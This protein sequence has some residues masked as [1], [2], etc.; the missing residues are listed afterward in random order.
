MD[1]TIWS[2][3]SPPSMISLPTIPVF[4]VLHGELLNWCNTDKSVFSQ[5]GS[6]PRGLSI[7][8]PHPCFWDGREKW[9]MLNS[10]VNALQDFYIV[11]KNE[12]CRIHS[13]WFDHPKNAGEFRRSDEY[14]RET[15]DKLL[16]PT[17]ETLMCFVSEYGIADPSDDRLPMSVVAWTPAAIGAMMRMR[18]EQPDRPMTAWIRGPR[19]FSA[20]R[21]IMP[22]HE[23]SA[24]LQCCR[25]A[26]CSAAMVWYDRRRSDHDQTM[27]QIAKGID[28]Y[29]GV[30]WDIAR[31]G[32]PD[33]ID[34]RT[35]LGV[36]SEWGVDGMERL[37][38]TIAA[39]ENR[40]PNRAA[41]S[42]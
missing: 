1:I 4:R 18:A 7:V 35:V 19:Q 27:A 41:E 14:R 32:A 6:D 10:V 33:G 8:L 25:W 23:F 29:R 42:D 3:P 36:L 39:T 30:P 26:R 21:P 11:L 31:I 28:H 24:M 5:F 9:Q 2:D 34:M 38:D 40:E 13:V 17:A 16:A 37:L 20:G 12:G 15:S 22:T